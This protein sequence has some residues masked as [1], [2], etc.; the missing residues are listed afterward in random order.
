MLFHFPHIL[1]HIPPIRL[2]SLV[3]S[4]I[5][6]NRQ[7]LIDTGYIPVFP[8]HLVRH[9]NQLAHVIKNLHAIAGTFV[10]LVRI[11]LLSCLKI[12]VI[13]AIGVKVL[14]TLTLNSNVLARQEEIQTLPSQPCEHLLPLILDTVAFEHHEHIVFEIRFLAQEILCVPIDYR[15]GSL[16]DSLVGVQFLVVN[17]RWSDID[18]LAALQMPEMPAALRLEH[19]EPGKRPLPS[20]IIHIDH[21]ALFEVHDSL[22]GGVQAL[23]DIPD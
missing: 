18:D 2:T 1:L 6:K 3:N 10:V 20:T 14:H 7:Q 23:S 17:G 4:F 22:L 15:L 11:P 8:C 21:N 19:T 16:T 13:A 5:V 12:L 9:R